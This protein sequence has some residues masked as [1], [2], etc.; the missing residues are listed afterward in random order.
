MIKQLTIFLSLIFTA[1]SGIQAQQYSYTDSWGHAGFNHVSSTPSSVEVVYSVPVFALEQETVNGELMQNIM[2]PGNFLFN[3]PGAPNLPGGGRFIAIP[4]GSVPHVKIINQRTEVIHDVDMMPAPVIP[5]DNDDNPILFAKDMAI[6]GNNTLYPASPVTISE[7]VRIRGTDAVI[8]GVTPFQYNPVTR[9]LIVYRDLKITVDCDG[10]NGTYG[11]DRMR[12]PYW[13]GLMSDVLMNYQV[14]PEIDYAGRLNKKLQDNPEDEE[15]EYIIITP[16]GA[17]FVRWADSIARFRNEQ[18]ILT[19]VFTVDE[20]GSNTTTA[21]ESF[22]NNAYNSWS[23]P[24]AACLLL[25]DYGISGDSGIIAPI[26][27]NY[28]ASDNIYADVDDDMMPDVIFGR[29]TANNNEQLTTFI[30]KLLDYER[31][32][33]TDTAY[34]NHPITAL[35]WQTERWFQIC[36]EVVGGYFRHV[37]GRQPNRINA[38]YQ[39]TPGTLWST[40]PN[41]SVVVN[42]FGPNGLGYI[43]ATPLDLGGFSGGTATMITNAL[44]AGAFMIQHRDHGNVTLWGEPSYKNNNIGQLNNIKLTHVFSI[45]CLTGKYNDEAEC[46]GEKFQ[47]HTWNGF[48]SG[49]LSFTGPS[50]TSYSF[51]NDTYTWGMMDNMWP[52]FMPDKESEVALRG[53]MPAF[54]NAGGKYFLKQSG[55]PYN[56]GNKAVTYYLFHHFG[57]AFACLYDTVPGSLDVVHDTSIPYGDTTVTVTATD[58]SFIAISHD[59]ELLATAWGE[60]STPIVMTVPQF[61]LGAVL[62]IVVTK[63]NYF[64]YSGEIHVVCSDQLMAYFNADKTSFCLGEGVNFTDLS[65]NDPSSWEWTFEGG[66]PG[67]SYQQDPT[68]IIYSTTGDFSVSL[69]VT[70][71]GETSSLTRTDYIHVFFAP[72]ANFED[73]ADCEDA[74][75]IFNDLSD[76]N[77]GTVTRRLWD[78]GDPLSGINNSSMLQNPSHTYTEPG[79]YIVSLSITNNGA[80]TDTYNKELILGPKPGQAGIPLGESTICQASTGNIFSVSP[81]PLATSYEWIIDSP[82]AGTINGTGNTIS[83]DAAEYFTGTAF[84]Y[85]RG[86]NDCGG[87]NISEPFT[88]NIIPAPEAPDETPSGPDMVDLRNGLNSTFTAPE[89]PGATGY[90]WKID[91]ES[92][93]SLNADGL[94]L[95][96]TWAPDF[97]GDASISYAVVS[98][99]CTGHYSQ[100]IVVKVKNTLGINEFNAYNVAV[101][102]NPNTGKFSLTI[103][104]GKQSEVKIKV[105]DILGTLVFS[106]EDVMVFGKMTKSIDFSSLPKGIYHLK[107]EGDSGTSIVRIVI[108]R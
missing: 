105:F 38:I 50:E 94:Q 81:I 49:A 106:E 23:T 71:N 8:L 35:G 92:A 46:F 42:Y 61:P 3:N 69:T 53:I 4:Q 33:E 54:G 95:E 43:P 10:G 102:P 9:D 108:D 13:D 55:W 22:I 80:C 25:G 7:V 62:K 76:P 30:T 88:L 75:V 15:C 48:N 67:T 32:P 45:N 57:D 77:G 66:S 44:N 90:A 29:M 20:V 51:V 100:P 70:K 2:L 78:F 73:N 98:E 52:D 65:C 6:Y 14:L 91:P 74:P 47:R 5:A 24:P 84:L 17:D 72:T 19:K 87:G 83:L 56:T 40:A 85:V 37:K 107:V 79:T 96:V 27:N 28:C 99:S 1:F 18:G 39:G 64:R 68:G 82:D 93:G 21:I 86:V 60:G 97:R 31:S 103:N 41:T 63:R 11:N 26:Y 104:S 101:F 58:S 89:V 36:S 34:Y 12:S 59:G 16:T